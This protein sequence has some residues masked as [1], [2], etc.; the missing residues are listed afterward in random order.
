MESRGTRPGPRDMGKDGGDAQRAGL[1]AQMPY[2]IDRHFDPLNSMT[3]NLLGA[4][5]GFPGYKRIKNIIQN[6][7]DE[8]IEIME[9]WF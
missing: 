5:R 7:V 2:F 3:G 8:V 6:R 9:L 1:R 4:Q